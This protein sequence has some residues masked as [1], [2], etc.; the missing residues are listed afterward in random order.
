[1]ADSSAGQRRGSQAQGRRQEEGGAQAQGQGRAPRPAPGPMAKGK[2][3]TRDELLAFI[4]ESATPVGKREIA[5]AYGLKG[6]QRIELKELLRDLRDAGEIAAG[7]RQDLPRSRG[8]DRHHRAGDR[9]GRRRRPPDRRAAP[10]RRREGRPAA[11]HRD[12]SARRRAART[13][14][15]VGDRVLASLKRRGKNAYEARIIRRLGSGPKKILGL[16]EEPPGRDGLGLVTP[17]DRKLRRELRR[18][19]GRQERRAGR[20]TSSGSRRPAARWRAAPACSS[21][22]GR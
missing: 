18:P 8:A 16:Y 7:P 2:V 11:A 10:P 5:R 6:D 14:P 1:M 4:R 3:P 9:P 22:S 19:A 15:A 20:A 21:A 13:A 17:T 12:R